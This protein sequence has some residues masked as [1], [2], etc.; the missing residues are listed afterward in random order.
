MNFYCFLLFW[1]SFYCSS[2]GPLD[3]FKWSFQQNVPLLMSISIKQKTE[4]VISDSP[5]SHHIYVKLLA[6]TQGLLK[7]SSFLNAPYGS[8]VRGPWRSKVN[9]VFVQGLKCWIVELTISIK[10]K[11]SLYPVQCQGVDIKGMN[12]ELAMMSMATLTFWFII[13]DRDIWGSANY[14]F[15]DS[16]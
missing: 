11:K 13:Q 9:T 12:W 15:S 4:N 7:H 14:S 1:E 8:Q 6:F 16:L 5:R 10:K 2:S 3:R